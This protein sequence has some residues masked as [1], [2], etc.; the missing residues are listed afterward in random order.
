MTEVVEMT[1]KKTASP[2]QPNPLYTI[3]TVEIK[4]LA[5]DAPH[6]GIE[7]VTDERNTPQASFN[8]NVRDLLF[9]VKPDSFSLLP[10]FFHNRA[11]SGTP[12][13][14]TEVSRPAMAR[15]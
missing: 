4:K 3:E 12:L 5:L 6:G 13:L 11:M 14:C 1:V 9:S 2:K 15:F 10:H 8:N 7:R